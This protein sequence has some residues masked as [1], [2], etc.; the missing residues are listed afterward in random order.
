MKRIIAKKLLM[1]DL[2]NMLISDFNLN[3]SINFEEDINIDI[4]DNLTSDED[5]TTVIAIK[6]NEGIII[7]SDTHLQLEIPKI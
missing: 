6:R 7:A 2:A 1:L 5:M 4:L 3:N